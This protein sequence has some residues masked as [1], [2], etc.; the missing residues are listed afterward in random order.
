M[1]DLVAL[2]TSMLVA[3]VAVACGLIFW[4]PKPQSDCVA[5]SLVIYGI[6]SFLQPPKGRTL[7]AKKVRVA[8]AVLALLSM[9]ASAG[10]LF[11]A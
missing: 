7:G 3:Y 5:I 11:L 4:F 2:R 1:I 8:L 6:L 10:F 9:L